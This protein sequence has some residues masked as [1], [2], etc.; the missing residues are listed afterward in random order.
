[1]DKNETLEGLFGDR[2]YQTLVQEINDFAIIHLNAQGEILSWNKGAESIFG[3]LEDEII[4]Q[5]FSVIFTPEDRAQGIPENELSKAKA[6]GQA[7]DVRWHLRKDASRIYATGVTTALIGED[8]DLKGY[9]KIARDNTKRKQIEDALL[10]SNERISNILES[11]TDAFFALDKDWR[12]TYLN[13]QT[14]PLLLRSREDLVG[15]NIWEEFPEAIGT[16]F[17]EQYHIA[18]A[19]RTVVIFEEF[20]PQPLNTWFEVRAYPSPEGLSVYFHNINERVERRQLEGLTADIGNTLVQ[21]ASLEHLLKRCAE[22]M[23]K[24]LNVVFAR[25]WT[26]NPEENVLELQASAGLYTHLDGTHSRVPVGKFKIGLIAEERLPHLTNDVLND[27]RVSDKEWAKREGMQSFAGYPLIV[28]DRLVG[29]MCAFARHALTDAA[30]EAMGSISNGIANGIER[31]RIEN[32]L[33]QSEEQYRLVA[34]TASDAVISINEKSTIL[35]INHAATRIFG[36]QTNEMLG[37]N[38]SMLMPEHMR[39]LHASGQERYLKTGKRHL[40]WEHV[41]VPALHR[42]GHEFPLE[43]SFGDYKK[44]NEHI[45]IGIA[46]DITERKQAEK[47]AS[48]LA[49]ITQDLAF[50]PGT[51]EIKRIIGAKIGKFFA[52]T[53]C[54]FVELD[55]EANLAIIRDDWRKSD[56]APSLAGVYRMEEYVSE[57]FQR[58][59][60]SG[61]PVV[62]ND[63]ASDSRSAE[64]A[65]RFRQLGLGSFINTPCVSDGVLKFVLGVYRG[66]ACQGRDDEIKLLGEMTTRIWLN[67]ERKR[68]EQ[69][70]ERLL[71]REQE[72]RVQAEEANKIKDEFLAT[73]SHELRTP[74]NAIL[75]WSTILRSGK[76]DGESASRAIETIER[77]ARSQSQLIDDLLDISRIITGK[78]RLEIRTIELSKIIEAAVDGVRPAAEARNI[79]LQILLD[80]EAGTVSGDAGRLQQIF[81]NLLTNAVKFTPK[82]GRVQVR[83]ERVNSHVEIVISDSGQGIDPKF[84]PHVFDRFRQADQSTTR[85]Q[86]G[87]GLGLSIVRQLVEMHGGTVHAESEGQ[88]EGTSFIVKLPRPAASAALKIAKV[89]GQERVHPTQPSEFVSI[90]R[91][92][93]LNDLRVLVVDDEADS[94]NLLREVLEYCGSQVTIAGSA[95]EALAFLENEDFDI[96]ISDIGMPEEDGYKLI[97][98]VRSLPMEKGGSIPAIA[99]TA[100]ARNEDRLRALMSGFQVHLPKPVEPV[101]L[102]AFVAS[103]AKGAGK[104]G[105]KRL[106]DKGEKPVLPK[107]RLS[108]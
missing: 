78:L 24:H 51:D 10:K 22:I 29:V 94:L 106:R 8:G 35:F 31:K 108:D 53:H 19:G 66:E 64:S 32:A 91:A 104:L 41:E 23:V 76:L 20:Y 79:R 70:R 98:K 93:Q 71:R 34:E 80:T 83:L 103:L 55:K 16:N 73:V 49:E 89:S 17:D 65:A 40:N 61:H 15:K 82:G 86:G 50:L 90:D 21:D 47:N 88:G 77:N 42:D 95:A 14:E 12:F 39:Y 75:G 11:I 99:L 69:E 57:D 96:L 2:P 36:Y 5:N 52:A 107:N 4:S 38:L 1:M 48:F 84:L 30:L 33:R 68:G 101:E 43:L 67:F 44:S 28:D 3:Y 100:Y 27:L 92:P 56:T 87:L 18:A 63:V 58:M 72:L 45:F 6:V 25:I 37:Q 97:D 7:E 102:A 60:V 74:L 54:A 62:I 9:A 26:F 59:L 81:W 85:R 105:S 46:R 13:K